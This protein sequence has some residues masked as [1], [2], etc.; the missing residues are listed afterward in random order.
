MDTTHE[1]LKAGDEATAGTAKT[2]GESILLALC[3]ALTTVMWWL[4]ISMI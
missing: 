4:T 3:D 2:K 1:N